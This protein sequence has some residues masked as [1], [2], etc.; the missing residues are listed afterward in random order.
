MEKKHGATGSISEKTKALYAELNERA[1]AATS[2]WLR[3]ITRS[4]Q[5]A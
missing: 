5:V 4:D 3:M 1:E 2:L